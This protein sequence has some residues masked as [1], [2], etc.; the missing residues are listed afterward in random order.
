MSHFYF[1]LQSQDQFDFLTKNSKVCVIDFYTK[2]CG[3][4]KALSPALEKK[5]KDDTDLFPFVCTNHTN[6]NVNDLKGKVLF[7]KINVEEHEKLST[8]FNI[9]SIPHIAFYSNGS[10]Q[11]NVVMGNNPDKII[12]IV[13]ELVELN[14]VSS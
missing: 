6:I 4:C 3:P 13:K 10:L 8:A 1:E 5:V 14:Q 7:V 11:K 9:S 12:S 2:W